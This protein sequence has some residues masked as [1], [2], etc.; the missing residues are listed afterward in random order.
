MKDIIEE[1]RRKRKEEIELLRE[2]RT[3]IKTALNYDELETYR[4]VLG[5]RVKEICEF[6][7]LDYDAE[8]L[9]CPVE[10]LRSE[11]EQRYAV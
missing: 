10:E 6:L 2:M 11:W 4:A 8:R 3:R 1:L 9:G 7:L 5:G